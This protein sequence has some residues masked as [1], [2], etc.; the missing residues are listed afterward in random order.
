MIYVLIV[1]YVRMLPLKHKLLDDIIIIII[2]V[3]FLLLP[4]QYSNDKNT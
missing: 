2:I 1:N 4:I 3:P